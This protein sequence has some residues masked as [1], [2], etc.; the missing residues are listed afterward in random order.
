MLGRYYIAYEIAQV[1][2]GSIRSTF[3]TREVALV[4]SI[5]RSTFDSVSSLTVIYNNILKLQI[6]EVNKTKI[7]G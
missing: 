6:L 2:D 4:I 1:H 5:L 7:F 3:K